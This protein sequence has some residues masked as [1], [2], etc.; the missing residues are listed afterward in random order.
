[1]SNS[2]ESPKP[3]LI[4]E[5]KTPKKKIL[6]WNEEN[7]EETGKDRGTRMKIDLPETPYIYP[8]DYSVSDSESHED[9]H[10]DHIHHEESAEE[11]KQQEVI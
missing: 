8:G 5:G 3:I 9:H 4:K 11:N 6:V 10:D 2:T 1:M 7:L